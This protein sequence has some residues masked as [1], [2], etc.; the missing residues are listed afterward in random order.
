MMSWV[1]T[2]ANVTVAAEH[3]GRLIAAYRHLISQPLPEGLIQTEILRGPDGAW[4]IQT[5]WRD[6]ASMEAMRASLE[7][8]EA[9]RLFREIHA[10]P[11]FSI[12]DVV[13]EWITAQPEAP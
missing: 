11:E 5:L 2:E 7:G 8:P 4:R 10:K 6:R 12:F 13:A 9:P 3:E 1:L